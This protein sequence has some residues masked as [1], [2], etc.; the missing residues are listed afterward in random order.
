MGAGARARLFVVKRVLVTR[1][2]VMLVVMMP[3]CWVTTDIGSFLLVVVVA[4]H[5]G[6][7]A[8]RELLRLV[9][10]SLCVVVFA[11]VFSVEL[12]LDGSHDEL[13]GG[14]LVRYLFRSH[15]RVP[16]LHVLSLVGS[17]V[18]MR[19]SGVCCVRDLATLEIEDVVLDCGE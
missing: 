12:V 13:V 18:L 5:V 11:A 6:H 19:S 1:A 8:V 7:L 16:L 10:A 9:E 15:S 17:W 2:R 4:D 14:R 3:P